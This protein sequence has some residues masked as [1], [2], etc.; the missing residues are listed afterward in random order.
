M[1]FVLSHLDVTG[2][3]VRQAGQ[4]LREAGWPCRAVTGYVDRPELWWRRLMS[5][6]GRMS[7]IDLDREFRRRL[8]QFSPFDAVESYSPWELLRIAA[9]R[10]GTDI[11]LVD[12]IFHRGLRSLERRTIGALDSSTTHVYCYEYSACATFEAATTLGIRKVYE[13]P[14]AEYEF[15]ERLLA[16]QRKAFPE[17][18]TRATPYFESLRA[19]RLERRRREWH[20][21]DLIIV[22]STFTL[23]TFA[24]AG[25]DT[26]KVVVVPLGAPPA[27]PETAVPRAAG[28]VRFLW[29][30]GVA[31]HK[32]A[33]NLLEAWR[34]LDVGENARLDIF[35]T[36]RLPER[37]RRD[38]P[39]SV[40][41][42]GAVPQSELFQRYSEADVLVFP[43]LCDGFGMVVTEAFAHGL[44]VITTDRAGASD[45]VREGENGFVV[46][47]GDVAQ[48]TATMRWC[49]EHPAVLSDMR[50]NALRTAANRPWA[51]YR[52]ELAAAI[53]D[54]FPRAKSQ[55]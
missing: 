21:A 40:R 43:T 10:T 55:S 53:A 17:L 12:M 29:A 52:A 31:V 30:G 34:N 9:I 1:R 22:N 49:I 6:A 15:V 28:P 32:G 16:E 36:W 25:L 46:R 5:L 39:P 37:C 27:V 4:A 41:L 18:R 23:K 2:V 45:L 11:R 33:H 26:S 54:A 19:R 7:G 20:L 8:L 48:L 42:H 14:S 47:G 24:R 51:A 44:P 35:G 3:F 38:L 50:G 13:V